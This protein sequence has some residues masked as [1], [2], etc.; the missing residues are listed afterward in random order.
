MATSG[1]TDFNL[2]IDDLIQEAFE[3]CGIQA[4]YGDQLSSARRSLNLLFLDWANRGL[5]LWTIE[6]ATYALVQGDGEISL[7]TETVNVLS[8]VIRLTIN[9]QQQ[10]IS[11]DRIGREEYLNLPDK[12]TQ[13]RPAQYYVERTNIPKL[14]LYP[15]A[16]TDYTLVYYRI[17]RMEDAGNYTNTSDVNF[18]F[19]PCLASGLAYMLSLKFAPE[20]AG[21]LKQ[22]YEEDFQRAALEDRD[23]ASVHFVPD[24][25]V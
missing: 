15:A 13:A 11:I 1:T 9:G 24:I 4:T 12:L 23:T 7:P 21:A 10:D 17:R 18:R 25:G 3:R 14:Y 16:N 20:R 22:I 19:L 6:Q 2:S 8:A 5:N